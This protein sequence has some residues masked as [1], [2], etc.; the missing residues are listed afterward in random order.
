MLNLTPKGEVY[1]DSMPYPEYWWDICRRI[2][3]Q[4]A[5]TWMLVVPTSVFGAFQSLRDEFLNEQLRGILRV[6]N[7]IPEVSAAGWFS[8]SLLLVVGIILISSVRAIQETNKQLNSIEVAKPHIR[9]DRTDVDV[10]TLNDIRENREGPP[11]YFAH[12]Y[13][14]NDPP[15][16]SASTIARNIVARVSYYDMIGTQIGQEVDGR[17]G[18]N[19][20]PQLR[21]HFTSTIDLT[22][23]DL[24]IGQPVELNVAIKH[25][26]SPDYYGFHNRI[27]THPTWEDPTLQLPRPQ[28][29]MQ[30]RLRGGWVDT[31]YQFLLKN[32]GKG[33]PLEVEQI[34]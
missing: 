2:I 20:Q 18:D 24:S 29:K 10:R 21:A 34:K 11:A 22:N 12:I 5:W 3:G 9:V 6:L 7:F 28:C 13:F 8:I 25:C 19:E 4:F 33:M 26:D 14:V 16:P 30:V 31:T 1:H 27:L 17:W 32:P 23:I 15:I